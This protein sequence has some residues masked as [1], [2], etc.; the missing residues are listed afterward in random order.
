MRY[1]RLDTFLADWNRLPDIERAAVRAW[2]GDEFLPAVAAYEA[3]P[4][5]YRWPKHLRFERLG[6]VDGVCAITWS[7]AGPDGRA[8]FHFDTFDGEPRLVWRRIGHHDI[9]RRP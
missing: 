3:D 9:Y 4:A 8:T 7:F 2:L 5:G 6:G 1:L